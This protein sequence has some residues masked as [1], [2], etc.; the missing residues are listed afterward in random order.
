MCIFTYTCCEIQYYLILI[1][2]GE[3]PYFAIPNKQV[4][5]KFQQKQTQALPQLF[6]KK[7]YEVYVNLQKQSQCYCFVVSPLL[8]YVPLPVIKQGCKAVDKTSSQPGDTIEML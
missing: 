8:S 4:Y 7:F 2:R 6:F 1:T 3:C 5:S